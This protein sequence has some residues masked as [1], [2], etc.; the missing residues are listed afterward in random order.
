MTT[1][2]VEYPGSLYAS[3]GGIRKLRLDNLNAQR[4]YLARPNGLKAEQ[5]LVL[6]HGISRHARQFIETVYPLVRNTGITLVAPLFEKGRCSD[7]QRLG[8]SGKGPRS[9]LALNAILSEVRRLTGWTGRKAFFYG[10]SAGAQFVQRYLFAHPQRV[11]RAA[12]SA[13]G[14]YTLP[15]RH[16]YPLGIRPSTQLPGLGFEPSRFLRVPAAVFVG[17]EDTLRDEALNVSWRIDRWQG[18]NRLERARNWVQAMHE[19][20]LKHGLPPRTELFELAGVGHDHRQAVEAGRLNHR[21]LE[22]LFAD[23]V[24]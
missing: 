6:V 2:P 5:V 8:R 23:R 20:A 4:Y 24:G 18:T 15:G 7:F 11:A 13:A 17:L 3:S 16:A 14:W 12:L 9:D 19:A 21:V 10:H 1:K 22:W